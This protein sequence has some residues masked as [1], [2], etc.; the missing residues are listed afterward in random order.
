MALLADAVRQA[1]RP[2]PDDDP[3]LTWER[4][5][6]AAGTEAIEAARVRRDALIEQGFNAGFGAGPADPPAAGSR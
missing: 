2:L 4:A 6:L 1:R 3:L 5:L